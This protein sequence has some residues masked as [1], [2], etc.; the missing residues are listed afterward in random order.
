[1]LRMYLLISVVSIVIA[2]KMIAC[3]KSDGEIAIEATREAEATVD[4]EETATA[5]AHDETAQT[6]IDQLCD[7]MEQRF[8]TDRMLPSI[9]AQRM[10]AVDNWLYANADP[11][12][13]IAM[14]ADAFALDVENVADGRYFSWADAYQ[15]SGSKYMGNCKTA[16]WKR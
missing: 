3:S 16:S 8:K 12:S 11:N 14:I 15:Q 1:M 13:E 6:M 10:R 2:A 4:A 9:T 7:A 5:V